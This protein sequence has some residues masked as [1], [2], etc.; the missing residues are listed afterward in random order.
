MGKI[1]RCILNTLQLAF[2]CGLFIFISL[3]IKYPNASVTWIIQ[4]TIS[5][6]LLISLVFLYGY[7][8][9]SKEM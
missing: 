1:G 5:Y 8:L 2:N 9:K 4:V 6:M 3:C 7:R